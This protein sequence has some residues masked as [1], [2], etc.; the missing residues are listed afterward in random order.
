MD[1]TISAVA[2]SYLHSK[3]F[4]SEEPIFPLLNI[5]KEL[6]RLRKDIVLLLDALS[7]SSSHLFFLDDIQ[8]W[9]QLNPLATFQVALVDHCNL[10]G[11]VLTGLYDQKRLDVVSI[12]DHHQD[13]NTFLSA[14][15]RIIRSCGSCSCLVFN[16]WNSLQTPDIDA[17]VVELLL[18]PLALDT[19]N[20]SHK[21][22]QDD[23]TAVKAYREIL[24]KKDVRLEKGVVFA[25]DGG[26]DN[27]ELVFEKLKL[28]KKNFEGY[29]AY[30]VL[31]KDF[32]LF[33]F[34][35][36]SE[37]PVRVGFS[38]IGKPISWLLGHFKEH[39]FVA[40]LHEMQKRYLL[41][42]LI[43]GTSFHKMLDDTSAR[44]FCYYAANPE[45][46]NLADFSTTLDLNSDVYK[47]D[48]IR[49]EIEKI[50][51]KVTFKVYNQ[52]N[53][54]FSRKQIVPVVKAIVESHY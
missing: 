21:V 8:S 34:C 36:K 38:S 49:K 35:G 4:P 23:L 45:Y 14:Y 24:A 3:K 7:I 30:D 25:V 20:L 40:A 18:A 32:K 15:P 5:P 13:E 52:V 44:E 6:L 11:S 48:K 12:I 46:A 22:E 17:S 2:Y 47:I 29:L 54:L 16:Y 19:A 37:K 10:Q 50:K 43:L 1:S 33:D 41:D 9:A 31:L 51:M 28:A 42:V 27:F 39:D 53:T 26:R